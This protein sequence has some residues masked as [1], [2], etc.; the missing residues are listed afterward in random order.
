MARNFNLK[1]VDGKMSFSSETHKALFN[2][3]LKDHEGK[4]AVVSIYQPIR[5][6]QQN[7]FYW[8]FLTL[9]EAET[10]NNA[11]DL[12]SYFKRALLPPKF[13]KIEVLGV[14]KEIKV[15]MSTTELTKAEMGEYLD[16]ISAATGISIPDPE[17]YME[18][19]GFTSNKKRYY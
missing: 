2:Q 7:K 6:T 3:F 8:T 19:E 16:K 13:I 9:I 1:I 5:T 10:G 4:I 11:Q 17:E 14:K 15:P 18:K 12:H